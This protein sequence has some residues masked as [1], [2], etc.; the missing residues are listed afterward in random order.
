MEWAA[1][2]MDWE[3]NKDFIAN[4]N[5]LSVL[6]TRHSNTPLLTEIPPTVSDSSPT[7]P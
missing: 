6:K 1:N 3:S 4:L 2:E 5:L 7:P